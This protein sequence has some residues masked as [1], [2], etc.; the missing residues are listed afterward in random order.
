MRNSSALMPL[1]PP[2]P[3]RLTRDVIIHQAAMREVNLRPPRSTRAARSTPSNS[4]GR[5]N[6]V[7]AQPSP[8]HL[9]AGPGN[10]SLASLPPVLRPPAP[11]AT[12]TSLPVS[13]HIPESLEPH[14]HTGSVAQL[15]EHRLGSTPNARRLASHGAA[16][17]SN[18]LS[19]MA[20]LS[21][22]NVSPITYERPVVPFAA[23]SLPQPSS[24]M[25]AQR[26]P[27][28]ITPLAMLPRPPHR[29]NQI[30]PPRPT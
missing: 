8:S 14:S 10:A 25:S 24:S 26:A 13:M 4:S 6:T 7:Q 16:N 23:A 5:S 20:L 17:V 27:S 30:P 12:S 29:S 15:S 3:T 18:P 11:P 28:A 19:R 1:Y 2:L 21:S 22:Y 9:P